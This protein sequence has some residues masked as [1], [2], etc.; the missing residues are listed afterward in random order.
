MLL[1][2]ILE[3]WGED[4]Q[5]DKSELDE[6]LAHIPYLHHKYLKIYASEKLVLAKLENDQKRLFL[7][8]KTYYEGRTDQETLKENNWKPFQPKLLKEDVQHYIA[9]DEEYGNL[10][11]KIAMQ[12]EKVSTLESIVKVINNLGFNIKSQIDFLRWTQGSL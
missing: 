11:L 7:L 3:E 8:K 6:K 9:A 2:K 10:L 5:V 12:K 1:E 4:C